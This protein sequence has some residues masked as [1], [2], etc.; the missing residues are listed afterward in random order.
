MT[1]SLTLN[2]LKKASRRAVR[3]RD[4]PHRNCIYRDA[5]VP[6]WLVASLSSGEKKYRG[7]RGK[8]EREADIYMYIYHIDPETVS[9]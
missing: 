9:L 2:N 6:T 3:L 8:K 7:P 1:S 5:E 4:H